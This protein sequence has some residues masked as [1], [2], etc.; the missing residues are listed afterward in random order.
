MRKLK[1]WQVPLF[2]FASFGPCMLSTIISV[3]L[4]DALQT[5]GFGS[6]LERIRTF[7]VRLAR[8]GLL[9]ASSRFFSYFLLQFYITKIVELRAK[10]KRKELNR[11][12]ALTIFSFTFCFYREIYWNI[13][14]SSNM[15]TLCFNNIIFLF[16]HLTSIQHNI[17]RRKPCRPQT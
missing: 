17:F 10:R 9:W 8:N 14:I 12:Q 4:V 5:A 2:A 6:D 16:S 15:S 7:L 11:S 1:R 3:Y 13:F